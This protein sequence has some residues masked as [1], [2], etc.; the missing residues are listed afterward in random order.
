VPRFFYFVRTDVTQ[1]DVSNEE[2]RLSFVHRGGSRSFSVE[3]QGRWLIFRG[4]LK[5]LNLALQGVR[6]TERFITFDIGPVEVAVVAF[7]LP[8]KCFAGRSR[9]RHP[10]QIGSR[11]HM[12]AIVWN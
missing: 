11:N 12:M 5:D 7:V 10:A 3:N 9:T 6:V 2:L 4:V 8:D 1:T